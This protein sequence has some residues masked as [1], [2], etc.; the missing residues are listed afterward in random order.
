MVADST[1]PALSWMRI[2]RMLMEVKCHWNLV[3]AAVPSQSSG[4]VWRHSACSLFIIV[5]Y[6]SW[7]ASYEACQSCFGTAS[8]NLST[9]LHTPPLTF[10]FLKSF[11]QTTLQNL[12]LF[13][14]IW[15][16]L[17]VGSLKPEQTIWLRLFAVNQAGRSKPSE[18]LPCRSSERHWTGG[19]K[20]YDPRWSMIHDGPLCPRD[21]KSPWLSSISLG[22]TW[23]Y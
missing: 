14:S 11:K 22:V 12:P 15:I 6:F 17:E 1:F 18:A 20:Q 21:S 10:F 8:D 23:C 13:G 9:H 5:P 3:A 16:Y 19:L 4:W 7:H 2:C